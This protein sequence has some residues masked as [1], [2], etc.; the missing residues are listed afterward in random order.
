MVSVMMSSCLKVGL[1]PSAH[2]LRPVRLL[3]S[4]RLRY[5]W[6]VTFP[7]DPWRGCELY[8]RRCKALGYLLRS[9]SDTDLL[10]DILDV[11]GDIVQDFGI[12]SPGFEHLRRTLKFRVDWG[13]GEK[14]QK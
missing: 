6:A 4:D 14:E 10:I 12:T 8:L 2:A 11:D 13:H 5:Y 7:D 3:S 9:G 1:S